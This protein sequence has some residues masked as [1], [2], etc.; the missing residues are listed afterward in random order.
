MNKIWKKKRFRYS[1]I[2]EWYRKK[3]EINCKKFSF[4]TKIGKY[5]SMSTV[6]IMNTHSI[7]YAAAKCIYSFFVVYIFLC[8]W[9]GSTLGSK[10]GRR[11]FNQFFLS[12]VY[13]FKKSYV[14]QNMIDIAM[15]CDRF[16]FIFVYFFSLKSV[17]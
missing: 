11:V 10:F 7:I 5:A 17:N 4:F 8:Q 15:N 16:P 3:N 1:A 6:H 9:E 14:P 13:I 12:K 2:E